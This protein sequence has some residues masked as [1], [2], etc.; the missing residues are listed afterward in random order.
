MGLSKQIS[1]YR[2]AKQVIL[3]AEH[4]PGTLNEEADFESRNVKDSENREIFQKLCSNLGKHDIDLFASRVSK[5]FKKYISWKT[6][7]FSIGRDAF[8][9]SWSQGL[10]YAF[11]PFNLIGRVLA[12]DQRERTNLILVTPAW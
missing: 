9:T 8:Q 5:Q 6:D 7:P 3:T 2:I 10:D 12:K 11:A 1:N 4:L